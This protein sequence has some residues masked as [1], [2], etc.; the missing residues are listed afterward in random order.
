MPSTRASPSMTGSPTSC[1]LAA[2]LLWSWYEMVSRSAPLLD[3][4]ICLSICMPVCLSVC[5]C[6]SVCPSVCLSVCLSNCLSVC[7]NMLGCPSVC[8]SVRSACLSVCQDTIGCLSLHRSISISRLRWFRPYVTPGMNVQN[9]SCA[10]EAVQGAED[11]S[12]CLT[13]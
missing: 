1:L 10:G 2:L 7:L 13:A 9:S 4:Y 11:V 6:L 5:L 8:S 12:K 3:F